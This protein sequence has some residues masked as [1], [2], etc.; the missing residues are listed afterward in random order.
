MHGRALDL[1]RPVSDHPLNYGLIGWWAAM[2]F[3]P[4][5]GGARLLD[6][7]GLTHGTL[8][9]G[10]AWA[11]S[12]GRTG[13]RGSVSFDGTNDYA[14]AT[15]PLLS[16]PVTI[17]CWARPNT[18]LAGN[19]SAVSVVNG[20][21][22]QYCT[23]S[24]RTT[25][26]ATRVWALTRTAGPTF[27][28]AATSTSYAPAA[29]NHVA[30]VFTSSTSRAAFLN[31]GNKGTDTTSNNPGGFVNGY[32]GTLNNVSSFFPGS[33]DDVRVY[34]RALSDAEVFAAYEQSLKGH[35]DT[36]RWMTRRAWFLG[37]TGGGG[38]ATYALTA[39]AGSYTVTG[40]DATLK[41][42]RT[43]PVANGSYNLSGTSV[44]LRRGYPMTV[45][46]GAYTLTGQNILLTHGYSTTVSSGDYAVTGQAVQLLCG[47]TVTADQGSY[48][49]TGQ[50][51]NL[52]HEHDVTVG[53]GSYVVTGQSVTL[54]RSAS[55][56][57]STGS[58]GVTGQPVSFLRTYV[59]VVAPESYSLNGQPVVLGGEKTVTVDPGSYSLSGQDVSFHLARALQAV[60]GSYTVNGQ[61]VLLLAAHAVTATAGS[62][63][64]NGQSVSLLGGSVLA[65]GA[66][67]YTVG[68]QDVLFPR[69]YRIATGSGTYAISG[70]NV[71][72]TWS[73][74]IPPTN[75][76][77]VGDVSV[78]ALV[79][80]S[81]VVSAATGGRILVNDGA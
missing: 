16:M 1:D 5:M 40:A 36:L 29:W 34:T 3:G 33:V 55:V 69:T 17:M 35:P 10:P 48:T 72:L 41:V 60:P 27:A 71:V 37:D 64:L 79:G 50:T 49:I 54:N 7:L 4:Y 67:S 53:A 8:T 68:G 44:L 14:L 62:Y 58:Y 75:D 32:V 52:K 22:S 12:M 80:G 24:F 43:L 51:V 61:A 28:Q 74:A 57:V 76:L 81:V 66:G 70:Q 63:S 21:L 47:H 42:A 23:L 38:G 6:L 45:Q 26:D 2:P 18:T 78:L 31:G 56:T 25:S 39:M 77:I 73:G 65:A 11:G 46:V 30:G 13:G 15:L 20:D 59:V 9:N 19:G